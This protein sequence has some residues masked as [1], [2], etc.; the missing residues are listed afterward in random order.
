MDDKRTMEPPA[1]ESNSHVVSVEDGSCFDYS[2]ASSD[3][4]T[5]PEAH[6]A[7][8][9]GG[10]GEDM[11]TC[12]PMRLP[13]DPYWDNAKIFLVINV[14][15]GHFL[16][17]YIP[18]GEFPNVVA[19][20]VYV[21]AAGYIMPSF[22]MISGYFSNRTHKDDYTT[23][24]QSNSLLRGLFFP[25]VIFQV[26]YSLVYHFFYEKPDRDLPAFGLSVQSNYVWQPFI[27][28]WF[29]MSLLA[30]RLVGPHYM[31]VVKYPLITSIVI[32]LLAGY[33][34]ATRFLSLQR[35]LA[36]FPFFVFGWLM[37]DTQPLFTQARRKCYTESG[38]LPSK[39]GFMVSASAR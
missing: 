10:A 19:R 5:E 31:R 13:R 26:I 16:Q 7:S 2:E 23:F 4:T 3:H 39:N 33:S 1:S 38:I 6:K 32:G 9:V 22:C 37:K 28:L 24:K 20:I 29:L 21:Y 8:P 15:V 14:C 25:Y 36:Y 35:S 18:Q 27:H 17:V 30:W 12:S 34:N 11:K